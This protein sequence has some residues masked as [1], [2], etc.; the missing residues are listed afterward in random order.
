METSSEV[1]VFERGNIGDDE[2]SPITAQVGVGELKLVDKITA[3]IGAVTS[4]L[5]A[6]S[7]LNEQLRLLVDELNASTTECLRAG[8]T[9]LT[10]YV[11]QTARASLSDLLRD[12][13]KVFDKTSTDDFKALAERMSS[14]AEVMTRACES[15]VTPY[16]PRDV[17]NL[18]L[19][20]NALPLGTAF[21]SEYDDTVCALCTKKSK[22]F[23][24]F[25][26]RC[27]SHE[28]CAAVDNWCS[29]YKC[30]GRACV[31]CM[32]KHMFNAYTGRLEHGYVST[33][34][35]R[36][37]FCRN[38]Q[39]VSTAFVR[40]IRL[41]KRSKGDDDD[42]DDSAEGNTRKRSRQ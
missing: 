29:S 20:W 6:I 5:R 24:E 21:S 11:K 18:L 14:W 31:K 10:R 23:V 38:A 7:K 32:E 27:T 28:Q 25:Y 2:H 34:V 9:P 30:A 26:G 3:D 8:S 22:Y 39:C 1:I 4:K 40:S 35:V 37:P 42:D 36:C 33:T 19:S 13:D 12:N 17:G 15:F 41:R 16:E